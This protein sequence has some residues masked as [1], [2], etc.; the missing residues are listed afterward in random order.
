MSMTR[1]SFHIY[2]QHIKRIKCLLVVYLQYFV[3]VHVMILDFL[4]FFLGVW[5]SRS[6]TKNETNFSIK[7]RFV[8]EARTFIPLLA[9]FPASGA[10]MSN[11]SCFVNRL[12]IS[13]ALEKSNRNSVD[14]ISHFFLISMF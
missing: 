9:N 3:P 5:Q 7:F 14:D 10:N 2:S 4:L 12:L 8:S 1:I 13:A 11:N 6:I